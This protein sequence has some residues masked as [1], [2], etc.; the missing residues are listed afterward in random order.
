MALRRVFAITSILFL[1]VLAIS[2]L[3]NALRPYRRFQGEYA[4]LGASRAKSMQAAKAY[5][6][7]P[8][9]IHQIWLPEFENRVDRCTTCHLG[10]QD[11]SMAGA[12]EPFRLHPGS[13]HT[14]KDFNRFGC[15]ACHGG[16]GLATLEKDAH[17]LVPD[18][19]APLMPLKYIE[20]GCGR[21]HDSEGV[22][23]AA[24]LS[25]GREIMEQKGLLCLSHG[26]GS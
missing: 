2:P 13:Y 22:S 25:L 23:G 3:K 16:Q 21:C 11:A 4:K 24:T 6:Q 18:A 17:G 26:E 7:K 12:Q 9:A 5:L 19:E 15:T 8:V 14:P 1:L 10:I 20:S